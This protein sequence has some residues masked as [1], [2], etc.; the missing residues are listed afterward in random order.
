MCEEKKQ[1]EKKEILY[2]GYKPKKISKEVK[3]TKKDTGIAKTGYQP[4]KGLD[5]SNPPKGGSGVDSDSSSTDKRDKK[6]D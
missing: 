6:K 3:K 4:S 1:Q 5:P 2:E